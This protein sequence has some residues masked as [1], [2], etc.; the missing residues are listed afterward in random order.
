[1]CFK[2]DKM[3]AGL[4]PSSMEG[5]DEKVAAKDDSLPAYIYD[6]IYNDDKKN[7]EEKYEKSLKKYGRVNIYI[8]FCICLRTNSF[9]IVYLRALYDKTH[10][11]WNEYAERKNG[12]EE[13]AVADSL[14]YDKNTLP[15]SVGKPDVID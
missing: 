8:Y 4:F 1:M 14:L 9:I 12:E 10:S 2:K 13:E 6:A 11:W 5:K 3:E 7:K 15:R